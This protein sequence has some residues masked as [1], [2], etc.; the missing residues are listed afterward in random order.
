[1]ENEL[2]KNPIVITILI[3]LCI[4][5]I[6]VVYLGVYFSKMTKTPFNIAISQSSIII[7]GWGDAKINLSDIEGVDLVDG[8]LKIVSNDGGGTIGNKIFGDENIENYGNVKCFI[9]NSTQ[10]SIF[11]KTNNHNYIINFNSV[12]ETFEK[13][14]KI[15]SILRK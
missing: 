15:K 7:E 11:I 3:L 14:N 12:E 10:K 5:M 6:L 4:T 9:E 1:M 2:K 13:F 8:N